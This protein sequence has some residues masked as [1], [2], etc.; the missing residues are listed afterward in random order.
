M[1]ERILFMAMSL[2]VPVKQIASHP[3]LNSIK[4]YMPSPTSFAHASQTTHYCLRLQ[5]TTH[6]SPKLA[7]PTYFRAVG[8]GVE[9]NKYV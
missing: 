1:Y 7:T 8:S 3:V 5:W 2:P 9:G 4:V 6:N